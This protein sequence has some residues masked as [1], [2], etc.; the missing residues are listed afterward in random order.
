MNSRYFS[1]KCIITFLLALIYGCA[2]AKY[3]QLSSENANKIHSSKAYSV[4]TQEE[5]IPQIGQSKVAMAMG[6]GALAALIDVAVDSHRSK[7]A[8]QEIAPLRQV[9]SDYDFRKEFWSQLQVELKS[10]KKFNISE[11][12][13]ST[14]PL[15]DD[16]QT[17]LA[18]NINEDALFT[19][20]T[21]YSLSADYRS[22]NIN[23]SVSLWLKGTKEK[24]YLEKLVYNS[25]DIDSDPGEPAITKWK[26]NNGELYR[27]TLHQ[28][29]EEII[30]MLHGKLSS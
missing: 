10:S 27:T 7:K 19:I 4:I 20:I 24:I 21:D 22:L 8:E 28:G 14:K 11:L 6:G 18:K 26:A 12:V 9:I 5:I 2:P 17:L 13:T 16:E 15:S 30:K 29:I 3:I 23:S 25:P 1:F